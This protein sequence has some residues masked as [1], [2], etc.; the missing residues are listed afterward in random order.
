MIFSADD[1]SSREIWETDS[2]CLCNNSPVSAVLVVKDF[3]TING[4]LAPL[5]KQLR[6]YPWSHFQRERKNATLAMIYTF[7]KD[8]IN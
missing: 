7:V 1:L 2:P 8:K 4:N 5:I 3:I 6:E